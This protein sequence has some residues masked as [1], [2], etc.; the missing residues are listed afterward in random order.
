MPILGYFALSMASVEVGSLA[1]AGRE[2]LPRYPVPAV[3]M[4]RLAIDEA[5][6]GMGL[7][8]ALLVKAAIKA[9]LNE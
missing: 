1:V 7:G 9:A 2:R 5:R 8:R 6:Q 4:T 3:L